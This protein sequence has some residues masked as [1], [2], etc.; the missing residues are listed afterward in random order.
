MLLPCTCITK[1]RRSQRMICSA[2]ANRFDGSFSIIRSTIFEM[3]GGTPGCTSFSDGARR[4]EF[5]CQCIQR[6]CCARSSRSTSLKTCANFSGPA[7]ISYAIRPRLY[8]S[9]RGSTGAPVNISGAMYLVVPIGRLVRPP[10]WPIRPKSVIFSAPSR[11]I[12]TFI[13]VR[14]RCTIPWA[15]IARKPSAVDR[16]T[17]RPVWS[18]TGPR[19]IIVRSVVPS[20]YSI[21][22]YN[23]PSCSISSCTLTMFAC[24]PDRRASIC[25]SERNRSTNR[26][27][28]ARCGAICLIAT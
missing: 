2:D 10:E 23:C 15:C 13:G 8:K 14:S 26:S 24:D 5:A 4:P 6:T 19:S 20:T 9:A 12:M 1:I 3:R 16:S 22:R 11:A 17:P 21:T 27:S 28:C 18:G 25:A 7:N